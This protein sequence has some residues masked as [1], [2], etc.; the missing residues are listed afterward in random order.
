MTD[1]MHRLRPSAAAAMEAVHAEAFPPSQAWD[2]SAFRDLLERETIWA[3]GLISDTHSLQAFLIA[4]YV[5]GEAEILTLAT[6][7]EKRRQGFAAELMQA[8]EHRLNAWGLHKWL[9]DVAADN[10]GGIAFYTDQGFQIDGRRINYYRRS[11]GQRVD[12]IL[13]SK[14]VGGQATV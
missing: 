13:M 7:P 11:N 2:A 10:P 8:L 9:L 4:Q 6:L 12:A 3:E 5:K 14:A 1:R